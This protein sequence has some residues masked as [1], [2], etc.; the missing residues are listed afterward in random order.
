ML[1]TNR[2]SYLL[3]LATVSLAFVFTTVL[4]QVAEL[5]RRM[6]QLQLPSVK[7]PAG[8]NFVE[9]PFEIN[10]QWM[11]IPVSVEGSRPLRF[12]L[13]S[14]ASATVLNDSNTADS[15]KPK[16][17][18]TMPVRGAGGGGATS[19]VNIA[20]NVALNVGGIEFSGARLAVR[21]SPFGSPSGSTRDGAIGRILFATL[22]VEIDW[23][24]RV[25]RLYDPAKYKYSGKGAILPLT[26]DE[27]GRPYT[28]AMVG[29]TAGRKVPVKLVVDT[30]GGHGLQLEVGSRPEIT[31]PEGAS[32]TVL[33]RGAGGEITGHAGVIQIFEFAGQRLTNVPTDFPDSSSGTAG[34]GG[35]HGNLGSGLLQRFNM[36]YDYSRHQMI[37]EPNKFFGEPLAVVPA[38]TLS[39]GVSS[40]AWEDY[41]GRY[42]ERTITAE[43]G[44]LHLQRRGGQK[45]KLVAAAKDEFSIE[46]IPTARIK[47]TRDEAG[48]VT[49]LQVLN[50]A[51]NWE[52][53][54]K[55]NGQPAPGPPPHEKEL[56][57]AEIEVRKLEREWLDAYEKRDVEAMNRILSDDFK[58]TLPNGSVRAKADVLAQLKSALEVG[59]PSAGFSTEDVRSSVDGET[60]VLT[61][62]VN[63]R[64]ER[65]GQTRTMQ[66]RYTDTYVRRE[67]RWQVKSSLLTRSQPQ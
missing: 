34:R 55:E 53:A 49:E 61:G 8:K 57:P 41:A 58:L 65:D 63:Q 4:A 26:F 9:I 46:R 19:E 22:V 52:T 27:G 48:Q 56:S 32:K 62:L 33:G 36:V 39:G 18:G 60:V 21:K 12:V 51:G 24:K 54:R 44:A 7:F 42:G 16:I 59:R 47:F 23:E 31:L 13:D 43:D 10:N 6:P 2:L 29:V 35:R 11:I 64:M 37:V 20:E 28:M 66:M 1:S 38:V 17:T 5:E 67:G 40:P 15:L 3:L 45:I 14:G 50:P 30:G 25:I